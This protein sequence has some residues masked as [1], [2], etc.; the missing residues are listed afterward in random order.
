MCCPKLSKVE[1]MIMT[2]YCGLYIAVEIK[3][4]ESIKIRQNRKIS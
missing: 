2:Y 1:T 4:A 3:T